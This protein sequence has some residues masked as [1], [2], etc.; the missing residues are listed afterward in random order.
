MEAAVLRGKPASKGDD[1]L[2]MGRGLGDAKPFDDQAPSGMATC[3]SSGGTLRLV[4][5]SIDSQA[6]SCAR[7]SSSSLHPPLAAGS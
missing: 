5:Y 6:R 1:I 4:S 2:G 7:S 3:A